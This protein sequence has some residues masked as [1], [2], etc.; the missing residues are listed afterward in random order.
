MRRREE[1]SGD[2]PRGHPR[3]RLAGAGTAA[4][5]VVTDA[6]TRVVREVGVARTIDVADGVVSAR[7]GVLV[8]QEERDRGAQ[9]PTLEETAQD[10][11]TV[12]LFAATRQ[13]ALSRSAPV[14]VALHIGGLEGEPRR[15]SIDDGAHRGAVRLTEGRDAEEAPC[16]ARHFRPRHL[17]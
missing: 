8:A 1:H 13:P 2:C 7:I 12:G 5:A 4:A 10:L 6:I 3:R 11:H 15:A 14:E 17:Q 9:G 16:A